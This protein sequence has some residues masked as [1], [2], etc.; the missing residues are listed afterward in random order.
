[1]HISRVQQLQLLTP[2]RVRAGQAAAKAAQGEAKA[3]LALEES[4]PAVRVNVGG[5]VRIENRNAQPA[6][7]RHTS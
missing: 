6:D 3:S 4:R 5:A 2:V 1:M 7:G